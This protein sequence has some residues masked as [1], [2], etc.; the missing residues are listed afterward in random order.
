MG[1]IPLEFLAGQNAETLGLK[2]NEQFTI[3]LPQ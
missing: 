3:E 2:G 1:I